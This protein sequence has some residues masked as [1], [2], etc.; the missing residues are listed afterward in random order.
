[1]NL[2]MNLNLKLSRDL[3]QTL[4]DL[5]F[6]TGGDKNPFNNNHMFDGNHVCRPVQTGTWIS[7]STIQFNVYNHTQEYE[8]GSQNN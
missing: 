1:M 7:A 4:F 3:S 2:I 8:F 6:K 5:F